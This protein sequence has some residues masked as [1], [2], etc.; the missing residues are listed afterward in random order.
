MGHDFLYFCRIGFCIR[1]QWIF[2]P[3]SL[4]HDIICALVA[5]FSKQAKPMVRE[6]TS[7]S[8]MKVQRDQLQV[9]EETCLKHHLSIQ[10]GLFL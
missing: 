6:K 1:H 5:V 4:V 10:E 3:I 2:L 9:Y 8:L 7:P